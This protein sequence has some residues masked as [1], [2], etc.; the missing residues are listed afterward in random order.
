MEAG[1][2]AVRPICA[3]CKHYE[4]YGVGWCNGVKRFSFISGKME[5]EAIACFDKNYDGQC[6]DYEEKQPFWKRWIR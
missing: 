5:S 6:T 1:M 3:K 4:A 2:D